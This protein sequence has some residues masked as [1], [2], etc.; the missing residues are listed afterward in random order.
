MNR[1]AKKE[2]R[3]VLMGRT[4]VAE[5][6]RLVAME[7]GQLK[8]PQGI[9]DGAGAACFFGIRKRAIRLNVS[10]AQ[11]RA[12]ELAFLRMRDIG[13]GLYLPQQPEAVA[14]LIRYVLTRP[15]V[16]IFAYQDEVP[17]LTA[18]SGR[19][20]TGWISNR[21]AIK[22]FTKKL[23]KGMSVSDK[24]V[25]EE[26]EDEA[27]KQEKQAKKEAK[28]QKKLEKKQKNAEKKQKRQEQKLRKQQAEE[29]P[30]EAQ[31]AVEA[32]QST[33]EKQE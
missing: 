17:V 31:D 23:P 20:L 27:R 5:D 21:R 30:K 26:K 29:Q 25:P 32:E 14:C 1:E 6:G 28:K 15:S 9:T 3:R 2:I 11:G 12:R 22:A 24:P 18:W 10:C 4:L 7:K 19:G 33:K 13:R 8:V 16:L